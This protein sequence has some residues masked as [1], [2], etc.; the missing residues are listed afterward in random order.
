MTAR[1]L[2]VAVALL[3]V[4]QGC[5]VAA[6]Q[7]VVPKRLQFVVSRAFG[8]D[9]SSPSGVWFDSKHGEIYVADTGNHRI[10]ILDDRGMP[11]AEI[12]RTVDRPG[13]SKPIPSEPSRIA[14]NSGGDMFVVD[15]LADY[16][17]MCD[18][19]GR[20]LR[21]IS[22]RDYAEAA[23][24]VGAA[25]SEPVSSLDLKATAVTVDS[26]DNVYIACRARIYVFSP[27]F[28]LLRAI[29]TKGSEPGQFT[30]ITSLWVD[31]AGLIYVTDARALAV[32]VLAADGTVLVAFGQ[33]DSG[34]TNFGLPI[35]ITTDM[36]GNI[37]VADTLRHIVSVFRRTGNKVDY[38]DYIGTLGT[39]GGEFA[40][41][42]GLTA[43]A[44]GK[45]LVVDR[46][47]G[48]VQCFEM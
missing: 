39:R 2:R 42:S 37:W 14:V 47:G 28:K 20:S 36:R 38:L 27:A 45:M 41:P 26:K 21:Q 24:R 1:G 33:H 18:Y 22:L 44:T 43:S 8:R 29:G 35:G 5:S 19:R 40:Y 31:A 3:L 10:V 48:R 30:A 46:V 6:A 4:A 23:K 25:P 11:K 9:F 7:G 15:V 12:M 16:V 32:H 13:S 17:D 34:V